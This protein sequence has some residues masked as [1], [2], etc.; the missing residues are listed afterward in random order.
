MVDISSDIEKSW[1]DVKEKNPNNKGFAKVVDVTDETQV[2]SL[3]K[4]TVDKLDKMDI[5]V[6]NAGIAHGSVPLVEFESSEI[7]KIMGVNFKGVFNG[8]KHAGKQMMEQKFG[9]IVNTGSFFGK[10]G[11]ANSS[12]Y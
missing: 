9:T 12:I 1:Q 2:A 3:I 5:M 4:E 11:H 6:N 8:C 7:D 10:V